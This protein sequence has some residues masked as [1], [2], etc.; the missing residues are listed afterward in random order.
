MSG[1]PQPA[2]SGNTLTW[3]GAAVTPANNGTTTITFQAFVAASV[4]PDTYTSDVSGTADGGATVMPATATAPVQV[5]ATSGAISVPADNPWGLAL[6]ACAVACV[7]A[8]RQR[9]QRRKSTLK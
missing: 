6:G 3:T 8:K 4:T 2:V 9:R 7:F 1:F 5:T